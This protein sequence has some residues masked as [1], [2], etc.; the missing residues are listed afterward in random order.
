MGK[1][2]TL[3]FFLFSINWTCAGQNYTK[4]SE[5]RLSSFDYETYHMEAEKSG[6]FGV[7]KIFLVDNKSNEIKDFE[8]YPESYDS[9]GTVDE[10]SELEFKNIKKIVRVVL[11]HCPCYCETS[12]HYWLITSENKWVKLPLIEDGVYDLDLKR[13]DYEFDSNTDSVFLVE[14]QDEII[15]KNDN[16]DPVFKL[17][18]TSVLS[19]YEW[20][21]TELIDK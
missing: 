1:W 17:K 19:T 9:D 4:S 5:L 6:E 10:S 18:S 15:N 3:I 14:F 21:G 13:L 2:I 8:V 11:T 20:N 12:K 7:T 16:G